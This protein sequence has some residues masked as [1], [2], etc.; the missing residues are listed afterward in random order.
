MTKPKLYWLDPDRNLVIED[1]VLQTLSSD[2]K[3]VYS[4]K[5]RTT[6]PKRKEWVELTDGKIDAVTKAQW[7][8]MSGQPLAAHRAY[9]RA[10]EAKLREVN[11]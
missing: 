3:R 8:G 9:A 10:V 4:V 7:G 11:T 1:S 2:Y 6:P 5:L